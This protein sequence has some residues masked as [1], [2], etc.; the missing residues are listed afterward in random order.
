MNACV[1][2]VR[3]PFYLPEDF[4]RYDAFLCPPLGAVSNGCWIKNCALQKYQES[5]F[6]PRMKFARIIRSQLRRLLRFHTQTHVSLSNRPTG[7]SAHNGTQCRPSCTVDPQTHTHTSLPDRCEWTAAPER[8]KVRTYRSHVNTITTHPHINL[9]Q[10][11]N[12]PI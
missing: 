4:D 11:K 5:F 9:T 8:T 1:R 6:R 12:E 10:F 7:G 3:N 2:V